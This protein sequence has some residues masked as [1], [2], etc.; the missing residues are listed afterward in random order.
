MHYPVLTDEEMEAQRRKLT[1]GMATFTVNNASEAVSSTGNNMIKL[2]L[3]VIDSAGQAGTVYD[4]LVLTKQ[5]VF[6]LKHFLKAIGRG[7]EY[8]N[9]ELNV[10]SLSGASG[11][12]TLKLKPSKDPQYEAQIRV[13]K[14]IEADG[15]A[16]LNAAPHATTQQASAHSVGPAPAP[17][18][19]GMDDDIPF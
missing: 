13:A 6:R 10:F 9:G 7:D 11:A 12:C 15:T 4:Y 5:M 16:S 17:S 19:A 1:E 14:Y 3:S 18:D 8:D 2:E